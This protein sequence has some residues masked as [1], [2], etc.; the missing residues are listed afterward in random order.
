MTEIAETSERAPADKPNV[1]FFA[2]AFF[3]TVLGLITAY[4]Q[5]KAWPDFIGWDAV[6]YMDLAD[7]LI[8][9]NWK[10]LF[11]A[12][13]SPLYP[14]I[15]TVFKLII[16]D[17]DELTVMA[18]VQMFCFAF[19][20]G[21]FIYF[22]R[23][24]LNVQKILVADDDKSVVA[25]SQTKL[26]VGIFIAFL[27]TTLAITEMTHRTPDIL[28]M[29]IYLIA[30][31]T[32]LPMIVREP[33]AARATWTGVLLGLTVW[34]K[35]FY[36]SQAPLVA[37]SIL[38]SRKTDHLSW[39]KL[40][41]LFTALGLVIGALALPVSII[42][43]K[44]TVSEVPSIHRKWSQMFGHLKIVHGKG[45]NFIHPTRVFTQ[46]PL[47]MEFATPFDVTYSPWYAPQYWYEG[48]E[49]QFIPERYIAA[50]KSKLKAIFN[51]I[52]GVF[53][54]CTAVIAISARRFPFSIDRLTKF[55]PAWFPA[56]A[57]LTALTFAADH[58]GRY[59][60][61]T[62]LVLI[63][64]Y[65]ASLR[66]PNTRAARQGLT[67]SYVVLM[68]WMSGTFIAKTFVHV[69]FIW[70][71]MA[72][73]VQKLAHTDGPVSPRE[74]PY[75]TIAEYLKKLGVKP[76]ERIARVMRVEDGDS[77]Y[78]WAKVAGVKIVCESPDPE[79]FWGAT[80]E[81]RRTAYEK[82]KAFGVTAIVQDYTWPGKPYPTPTDP[83]WRVVPGTK[84][85]IMMLK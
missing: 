61:S 30:L 83:E 58:H 85:Y 67:F 43:G 6:S 8:D 28:A 53:I 35:N 7:Q 36:L 3:F 73:Q 27:Y 74:T 55:A 42:A 71:A 40:L 20:A 4:I 47:I 23:N 54:F 25:L 39:K 72:K 84:T 64:I 75:L 68:L 2:L 62:L 48:N 46:E 18:W 22:A 77:E 51:I 79:N 82:L 70:P 50:L 63:S 24:L 37:L 80:P 26:T 45:K 44:P 10:E 1:A 56:V 5:I 14:L 81:Q 57:G 29:G 52:L 38:A 19:T 78:Y 41:M 69:Y 66:V 60:S 9:G 13:W 34:A 32:W 49:F 76:G 33:S 16:L 12:Y 11:R 21:A 65:L 59:Y 15:I 31:G 17:V